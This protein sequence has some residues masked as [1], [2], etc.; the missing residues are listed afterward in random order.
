MVIGAVEALRLMTN[1]PR[2]SRGG[3]SAGATNRS[4]ML[5]CQ[6]S[7][8][9]PV[10]QKSPRV[11]IANASQVPASQGGG[12]RFDSRISRAGGRIDFRHRSRGKQ[13]EASPSADNRVADLTGSSRVAPAYVTTRIG[14]SQGSRAGRANL[15]ACDRDGP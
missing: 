7:S 13:A 6:R 9:A 10:I 2:P 5:R 8:A 3:V 4:S 1:G 14:A 15:R 12:L 11:V